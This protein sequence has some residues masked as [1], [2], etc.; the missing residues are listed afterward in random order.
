LKQIGKWFES[1]VYN[2]APLF[3]E[4]YKITG[5]GERASP[6][7]CGQ[8]SGLFCAVTCWEE[9]GADVRDLRQNGGELRAGQSYSFKG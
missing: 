9:N 7:T 2:S 4:D 6:R 5:Y 8:R 1:R 3:S